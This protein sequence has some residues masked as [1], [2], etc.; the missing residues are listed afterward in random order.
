MAFN[1]ED[2]KQLGRKFFGLV[3]GFGDGVGADDMANAMEALSAGMAASD[4]LT[5][6]TDAAAGFILSGFAEAW[7]ESR[8]DPVAP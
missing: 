6:D 8:I 3:K 5:Q 7:A 4:E 1:P 2:P